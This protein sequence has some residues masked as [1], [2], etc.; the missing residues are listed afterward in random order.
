MAEPREA[1]RHWVTQGLRHND[2]DRQGHVN[3]AVFLTFCESA[4]LAFLLGP[5]MPPLPDNCQLVL[6]RVELDY[7]AELFWPGEVEV[8]LR[9]VRLGRS[10]L[11]LGEGVFQDERCMAASL[12]VVVLTDR[13]THRSTPWPDALRAALTA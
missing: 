8:G 2:T 3:N 13:A 6:A 11:T 9:I 12:S 4:R 10:S 5:D 7:L 1:Y